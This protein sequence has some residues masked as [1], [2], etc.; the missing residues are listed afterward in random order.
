MK[1]SF[2]LFIGLF[3]GLYV[4]YT[5]SSN[6]PVSP[7]IYDIDTEMFIKTMT[8]RSISTS[9]PI[10]LTDVILYQDKNMRKGITNYIKGAFITSKSTIEQIQVILDDFNANSIKLSDDYEKECVNLMTEV[11]NANIFLEWKSIEQVKKDNEREKKREIE[12]EIKGDLIALL[13]ALKFNSPSTIIPLS[14]LYLYNKK[15]FNKLEVKEEPIL[16]KEL[17]EHEEETNEKLYSFSKFYCANAFNLQVVIKDNQLIIEGDKMDYIWLLNLINMI[18]YNIDLLELESELVSVRQ[19]LR[20]LK[21]IIQNLYDIVS[22]S[23]HAN[24]SKKLMNPT[25]QSI[26]LIKEYFDTKVIELKALLIKVR[27]QFPE[28]EEEIR[29]VNETLIQLYQIQ[30]S[31]QEMAEYKN[32]MD[33]ELEQFET[34]Q[35]VEKIELYWERKRQS[36]DS[37]LKYFINNTEYAGDS[38][39]QIIKKITV[40]AG[41]GPFGLIKGIGELGKDYIMHILL[42]PNGWVIF[43]IGVLAVLFSMGGVIYV[44]TTLMWIM[45]TICSNVKANFTKK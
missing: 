18:D 20:I 30:K 26:E 37:Y 10:N 33:Y 6:L 2:S 7:N 42:T 29:R 13:F 3:I 5:Y 1:I 38:L 16:K 21:T 23:A 11:Y 35:K 9:N 39:E 32:N 15:E 34:R 14:M 27:Q 41:K 40:Y 8:N 31:E 45:E 24:L 12:K 25:L 43:L 4:G 19:R 17:K 44:L 22:F 36:L 28:K